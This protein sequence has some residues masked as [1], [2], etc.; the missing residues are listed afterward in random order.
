M[1][2]ILIIL[3]FIFYFLSAQAQVEDQYRK[4]KAHYANQ[5]YTKALLIWEQCVKLDSANF[6]CQEQAGLSAVRLGMMAKAKRY[7]HAIEN[8]SAYYKTAHI[9]LA[10]IYEQQ[11]N[12]PKAIRYNSS[13]K[14]S[15][16]ENFIYYRKLGAL[17][18]KAQFP[19]DAFTNY[20]KS[21]KINPNDL[22]S[23]KALSGLF[24]SN[25]Q[26]SE[27]DSLLKI[28]I[29]LDEENLSLKLLLARN[30]YIQK[31]YDSTA[32]VM[33]SLIGKI[34][35]T[36]YYNR[37][38]GYSLLQI[39]STDKAIFYLQKSLVDE[40]SPEFAH[41]Y[42][43]NAYEIK[44]DFETS[45]F[46]YEEAIIA[47]TSNGLH[48]YHRN[49]ARILK[50][51]KQLKEA[52]ENYK[53]AIKYRSDPLLVLYLAQASDDYYKDKSIAINFYRQYVRST[54]E[55]E[56]YKRYAKDRIQY[57]KEIQHLQSK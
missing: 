29:L 21:L 41:Y 14:D 25:A 6:Y 13:L 20:A 50:E 55:N 33:Q 12:I 36:N 31:M 5:E 42:L 37:I 57:L 27:A 34:D 46:H 15:F 44:K 53:W 24:M 4:A 35:F 45:I 17:Y 32:V 51:S 22:V 30:Y 10:S 1:R 52:I 18:S 2:K 16:P 56:A 48:T 7:F 43:A 23:I 54:D 47:G 38:M 40:S 28:G 11:E 9:N 49:L 19:T 8:D 39:D 26:Y 3:P